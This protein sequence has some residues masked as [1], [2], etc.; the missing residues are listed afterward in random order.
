[1]A[2]V[3][4]TE[5][6]MS[7]QRRSS[8]C[9]RKDFIGPPSCSSSGRSASSSLAMTGSAQEQSGF[10]IAGGMRHRRIDGS[11]SGRQRSRGLRRR[12]IRSIVNFIGDFARGFLEF[13]DP[14]AQAASQLRQ[15]LGS[16]KN[17]DHCENQ[18]DFPATQPCCN[19]CIHNSRNYSTPG[20]I[21]SKAPKPASTLAVHGS[22]A[23]D[24]NLM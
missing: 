16:K 14:L 23:P 3:R 7:T 11:R 17:Q 22:L 8:R 20:G 1:M 10:G 12:V 9:S 18:D 6:L 15:L 4:A 5:L 13:L 24:S 2:M 21:D 19:N